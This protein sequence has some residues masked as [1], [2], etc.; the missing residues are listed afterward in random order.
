MLANF[1]EAGF[2]GLAKKLMMAAE[3][4]VELVFNL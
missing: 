4:L 2:L 3:Y 1:L